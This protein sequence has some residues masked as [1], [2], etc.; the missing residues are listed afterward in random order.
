MG[1]HETICPASA[2]NLLSAPMPAVK[3]LK[4]KNTLPSGDDNCRDMEETTLFVC[5]L[6]GTKIN[7]YIV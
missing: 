7:L 3:R 5:F 2:L 4:H 1:S 6:E